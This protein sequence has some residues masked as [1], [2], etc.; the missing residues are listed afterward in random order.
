[1]TLP[2]VQVRCEAYPVLSETFVVN[3]ARALAQLGHDVEVLAHERPATPGPDDGG[4]PVVY[5]ED[6]TTA[7][8]TLAVARLALR[9]PLG[10]ARD[11]LARPRWRREEN[12]PPLRLLAPTFERIGGRHLHV[13]FAA[14][15]ALDALRAHR[16]LGTPYSVT[17]HAYDIYARPANLREK[18]EHAAFATTGCEYT[19]RTLREVAPAARVEVIVMGVDPERLR[20]AS[21]PATGRVV[22]AIGRLVEKKGFANLAAAAAHLDAEVRVA[23]DGPLRDTLDG[24]TLLGALTPEQIA[25]ELERAAVLAVPCVIAADGDRDSMPVVAKEALAMEVPVVAS[26]IAGLPELI[27]PAFGRLVPP[28][29]PQALAAALDELLALSPEERAEMGRAGRAHVAEHAN[30]LTETKKLSA[31]LSRSAGSPGAA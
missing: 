15:S 28:G 27:E 14:A 6:D 17:A 23:G 8:R 18:L 26:D 13:H 19:A 3:E 22:L 11:L 12:V 9:H 20:R 21:P 2:A 29:D 10:V 30:L 24:V 25:A 7:R 16:I 31:L 1:M 5:R 4:V